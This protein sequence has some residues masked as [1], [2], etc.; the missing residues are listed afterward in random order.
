MDL[1]GDRTIRAPL[2]EWLTR[3]EVVTILE[4]SETTLDEM[5]R[6]GQFPQGVPWTGKERRWLWLDVVWRETHLQVQS[7][8]AGEPDAPAGRTRKDPDKPG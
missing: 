4:I 7:R 3:L 6:S 2:K 5:I 8:L 1:M